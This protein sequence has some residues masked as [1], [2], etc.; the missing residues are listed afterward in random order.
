MNIFIHHLDNLE[1]SQRGEY[2]YVLVP[3]GPYLDEP[4]NDELAL[5]VLHLETRQQRQH[6]FPQ[7]HLARLVARQTVL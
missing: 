7:D 3:G 4:G 5:L 2:S 1:E 6:A